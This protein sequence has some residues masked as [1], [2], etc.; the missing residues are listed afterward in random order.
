[1]AELKNALV[2]GGS[3]GIGREIVREL[4]LG[5]NGFP[6]SN[7]T[8]VY[9]SCDECAAEIIINLKESGVRVLGLKGDVCSFDTAQSNVSKVIE[10]FGTLDFFN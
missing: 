1:L 10:E 9:R 7:V 6:K 2:T 4:A 5:L 8:F 3:R